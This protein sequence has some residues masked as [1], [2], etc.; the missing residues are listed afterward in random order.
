MLLFL[1]MIYC[2]ISVSKDLVGKKCQI[3]VFIPAYQFKIFKI[4]KCYSWR[5]YMNLDS[6]IFIHFKTLLCFLIIFFEVD[7]WERR[8]AKM[9]LEISKKS[10]IS[11][12]LFIFLNCYFIIFF[13]YQ[14]LFIKMLLIRI[15]FML[16]FSAV[17]NA[18][19]LK[20]YNNASF[21]SIAPLLK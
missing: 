18:L 17:Y 9:R 8:L 11:L 6:I 2:R 15:I 20:I 14:K 13:H 21:L 1:Y 19:I 4:T 16:Y 12:L 3:I 10:L 7:R 5:S